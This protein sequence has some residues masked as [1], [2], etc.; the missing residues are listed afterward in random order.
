[1]KSNIENAWS[2]TKEFDGWYYWSDYG[3][4][5]GPYKSEY[6]ADIAL[7]NYTDSYYNFNP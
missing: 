7:D 2:I 5:I 6:E 3:N 4:P 1:M